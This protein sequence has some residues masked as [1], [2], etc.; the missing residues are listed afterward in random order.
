MPIRR[1][2]PGRHSGYTP[3]AIPLRDGG[4]LGAWYAP[5]RRSPL[6]LLWHGLGGSTAAPCMRIAAE[7][8]RSLGHGVLAINHRGCA[9]FGKALGERTE[10]PY[11]TGHIADLDDTLTWVRKRYAPRSILMVGFSISGNTLLRWLG[12]GP[13]AGDGNLCALAVNPVI[14]L[15]TT[16]RHLQ[17]WPQRAYDLWI[18]SRCRRWIPRFPHTGGHSVRVSPLASLREFDARYIAPLWGFPSR[19]AYYAQAS[20]A[21][22]LE[23][24]QVPTAILASADDPIA[25]SRILLSTPRSAAVSLHLQAHGGHLGYLDAGRRSGTLR[26][27]LGEALKHYF[28]SATQDSRSTPCAL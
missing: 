10:R 13:V 25:S 4:A 8:G 15:E 11:M 17:R 3:L 7:T 12:D 19:D 27:W 16:S 28:T 24:I 23:R 9:S 5:G 20:S 18:L 26:R 6:V 21:P 2:R 14:D 1:P 22:Y